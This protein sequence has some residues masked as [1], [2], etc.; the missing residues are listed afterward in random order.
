[1]VK[2]LNLFSSRRGGAYQPVALRGTQLE[3]SREA[4]G[5]SFGAVVDRV[6]GQITVVMIGEQEASVE[7]LA[8]W[9][10]AVA[11]VEGVVA[12]C[13]VN[14][15]MFSAVPLLSVTFT[16][17]TKRQREDATELLTH[18][19]RVYPK[20]YRAA[21][22][23]H[24]PVTPMT[25]EQLLSWAQVWWP[26]E[27][28]EQ[29]E[30]WP[31][32]NGSI[33]RHKGAVAIGDLWCVSYEYELGDK[34]LGQELVGLVGGVDV[35]GFVRVCRWFRP[36]MDEAEQSVD[37]GRRGGIVTVMGDSQQEAEELA[38]VL[39]GQLSPQARLRVRRVWARQEMAAVAGAG[40]GVLGWQHT[41][42]EV[43]T[44]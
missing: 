35:A 37:A 39:L 21:G 32:E 16:A 15:G 13:A 7:G 36:A 1:M 27:K 12:T 3:S 11:Q 6:R 25:R 44:A 8:Q 2:L 20:L 34:G 31:P 42:N 38:G 17:V 9:E 33:V 40:V 41:E 19:A 5:F 18:V 26:G 29:E 22:E 10:T 4:G 28:E 14:V 23:A 43:T 24:M 30:P